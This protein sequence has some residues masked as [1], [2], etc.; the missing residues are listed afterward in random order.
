M[1]KKDFSAFK[2]VIA[3]DKIISPENIGFRLI[4]EISQFKPFGIGNPKPVFMMENL[5]YDAI[6]YL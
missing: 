4:E 1:N 5:S 3:V 6:E 2:K